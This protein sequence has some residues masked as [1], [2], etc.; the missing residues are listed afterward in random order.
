ARLVAVRSIN[1]ERSLI[2]D[3]P[4]HRSPPYSSQARSFVKFVAV[5]LTASSEWGNRI[6]ERNDDDRPQ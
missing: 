5:I 1:N 2:S 6:T 4:P 3:G